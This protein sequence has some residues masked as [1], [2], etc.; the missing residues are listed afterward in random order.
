VD[1]YFAPAGRADADTLRHNL[2]TLAGDPVVTGLLSA[3][4]GLL[5]VLN[6]QRQ[7]LVVNDAFLA[8]LQLADAR[9]LLGLRPGEAVGCV[10]ANEMPGGCGTS[11]FCATCG[12]AVALV[13]STAT[14]EPQERRCV[15]T[16][17]RLGRKAEV[18]FDVRSSVV[19]V[20]GARLI[21]LFLQ[22]VT[23]AQRWSELERLFFHDIGNLLT[24][25]L[26]HLELLVEETS[27][28][29]RRDATVAAN[30]A[31]RLADEIA[32]QKMLA[33]D[34]PATIRLVMQPVSVADVLEE[35]RSALAQHPAAKERLLQVPESQ[36]APLLRTDRRLLV[37][38]LTN[39]AVNALE[40]T[41]PGGSVR[42]WADQAA[43]GITF[44][45]WNPGE[46]PPS[47][48]QRVFQRHFS[49]K[50]GSARG[51]GTFSMKLFG[52]QLLGGRVDFTTSAREGTVFRLW[53][54][55]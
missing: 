2:N 23:S 29:A 38:V 44:H 5:A 50:P 6:E 47:I 19:I 16:V 25:V 52:E 28:D 37:R 35:L 27:G 20:D 12:A 42:A 7:I 45:V 55:L 33:K 40:A 18:C 22:D 26:G 14:T 41:P 51:L 49:T 43:S 36:G 4:S 54:P 39:M 30:V 17:D 10:H 48:A 24:A 3:A 31:N 32:I 1:T 53:L 46:I 34:E 11:R 15:M 13:A 8:S 21:L 9:A